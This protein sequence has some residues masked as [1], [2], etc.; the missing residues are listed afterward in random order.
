MSNEKER[1]YVID[2]T[3]SHE[4]SKEHVSKDIF[5]IQ[6]SE[7][8]DDEKRKQLINIPDQRYSIP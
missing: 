2:S 5:I 8:F 6:F 7:C 3:V 4:E 1:E